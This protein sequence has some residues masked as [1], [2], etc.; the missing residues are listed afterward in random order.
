MKV[1]KNEPLPPRRLDDEE[2]GFIDRFFVA[3]EKERPDFNQRMFNEDFSRIFKT[4]DQRNERLFEVSS[5]DEDLTVRLLA[6]V[7]TRFRRRHIDEIIREWLSEI[8]Q[9]LIRHGR[10]Y[11]YI[12]EDEAGD[13]IHVTPFGPSGV[14]RVLGATLQWVPKRTELHFDRE[15]EEIPREIRLLDLR[16]TI[17]FELPKSICQILVVQN[18]TLAALDAHQFHSTDS[19]PQATHDNPNPTNHFDYSAWRETQEQALYRSTRASGWNGRKHDSSKRS[20]F[21]DCHRMIRFR[22][23]Q[24]ILRDAML[25]QLSAELTKAGRAFSPR[26]SFKVSGTHTLS[27]LAQLD[28]LNKR[29]I[30]EEVGFREIVDFCSRN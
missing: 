29:L 4:T 12:R 27:S 1:Y 18:K 14:V 2:I 26:Y 28:E 17:R 20:D 6:N 19:F 7:H 10:A 3:I 23:N 22:R 13:G 24:L 9:R 15:S 8:A 16:K 30:R 21:F 11:Y 5:S 25:Q